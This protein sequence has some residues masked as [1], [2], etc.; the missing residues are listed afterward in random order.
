MSKAQA[1][2]LL[3]ANGLI[4][5][6]IVLPTRQWD[7]FIFELSQGQRFFEN[8]TTGVYENEFFYRNIKIKKKVVNVDHEKSNSSEV[9][10]VVER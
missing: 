3:I 5:T 9:K 4:P 7:S 6:E 1:I 10:E 2:D 8:R